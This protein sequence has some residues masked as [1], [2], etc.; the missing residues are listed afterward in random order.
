MIKNA[1]ICVIKN[2]KSQ[3]EKEAENM[4][5]N[6][7][8]KMNHLYKKYR[9]Y[10]STR[11]LTEE[12]LTNRQISV[13]AEEGYLE[14]VCHGHYWMLQ[15]GYEKPYDYKCIEACLS[16]PRAVIS[17]KSACFYQGMTEQEPEYLTVSTERTDRSAMKTNFPIERHFFSGSNFRLGLK[18]VKTE[19]GCYNIYDIERSVCDIIRLEGKSEDHELLIEMLDSGRL[20]KSRYKRILKYAQ[21]FNRVNLFSS[22]ILER[23]SAQDE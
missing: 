7:Y 10:T 20:E 11:G 12:G 18:H 6:T 8:G 15:C 3:Q 23:L 16:N 19:F 17:M 13:L 5:A 22:D 9:G 14:R 2:A 21:L 1:K 4:R